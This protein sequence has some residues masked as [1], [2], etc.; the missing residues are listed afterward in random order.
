MLKNHKMTL[1]F[2]GECMGS[3]ICDA[4]QHIY[5]CFLFIHDLSSLDQHPRHFLIISCRQACE[6]WRKIV[7][8]GINTTVV[9]SKLT[10]W[11]HA[12]AQYPLAKTTNTS[13]T[14]H[15]TSNV[16]VWLNRS[17]LQ[18]TESHVT[19]LAGNLSSGSQAQFHFASH[20][21]LTCLFNS[22]VE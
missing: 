11:S 3:I 5:V 1:H 16:G 7:C 14:P 19:R 9:L 6:F 13:Q 20:A 17:R 12:K 10:T 8:I 22:V 4:L 2:S 18:T 21:I 15:S